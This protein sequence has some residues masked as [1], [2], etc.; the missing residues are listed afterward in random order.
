MAELMGLSE[1]KIYDQGPQ[2]LSALL[3]NNQGLDFGT[4]STNRTTGIF[5]P[6]RSSSSQKSS[7]SDELKE[8]TSSISIYKRGG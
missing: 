6:V 2:K 8:A 7:V 3:R 5:Q 4:A 1:P